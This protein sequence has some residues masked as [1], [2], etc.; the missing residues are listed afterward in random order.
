M[1]GGDSVVKCKDCVYAQPDLIAS[2]RGWTAFECGN[3]NSEYVGALLNV[4]PHG[5]KLKEVAWNGCVHG[6]AKQRHESRGR[7]AV[8]I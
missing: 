4:S 5:V 2:E 3:T 7:E 6:V 8:S 1:V